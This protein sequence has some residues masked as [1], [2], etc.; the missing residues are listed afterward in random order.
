MTS[1]Q[2]SQA[3]RLQAEG[4]LNQALSG[5]QFRPNDPPPKNDTPPPHPPVGTNAPSFKGNSD[6]IKKMIE[7]LQKE[8]YKAQTTYQN[9]LLEEDD[10][11]SE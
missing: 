3:T 8:L 7:Y 2:N 10:V 1:N 11:Q 5:Q 9:W 6:V 4:G